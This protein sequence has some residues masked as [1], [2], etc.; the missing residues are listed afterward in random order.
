MPQAGA[1]RRRAAGAAASLALLAL[2]AAWILF[3]LVGHDPWKPDEAYSFGLV[4]DFL[5]RGD[6]VVP[7]LAGE[8]FLEKPPLFFITASAFA[9]GFGGM[10]PLHDAARLAGGFYMAVALAFLAATARELNRRHG[11][12]SVLIMLGCLGLVVRAH[13]L[14]TDLA[15]LAGVSMGMF[16]LALGR[17]TAL[18]GLALGAGAAVAFLSKGML[19]PGMLA[20]TALGLPMFRQWRQRTYVRTLIV[21]ALVAFP[22]VAAWMIALYLRSPDLFGTWLVT[23]NLGR[24]FGF[25]NIGPHQP[26]FFYAYTLLWYAFP[27]LPL[28]AWASVDACRNRNAAQA[29]PELQ[30]PLVLLAVVLGVL[31][32]AA[33]AR[34]LYLMPILLPLALLAS[35]GIERLPPAVGPALAKLGKGSFGAIALALWLGWIALLTGWPAPLA[36]VLADFQPGYVGQFSGP[37]F[38]I[39]IIGTAAWAL[40]VCPHATTA[41]LGV[42][43]W[44]FGV[45]LSLVLVGT[46]WLPYLDAGKSYRGMIESLLVHV[47]SDTCVSSRALGEPQR[48]MLHYYGGLKTVREE[49]V[50]GAQCSALLVQ[51][52]RRSGAP[53]P[54]PEWVAVWEGARPGDRN[55]LYVLYVRD[56]DGRSPQTRDDAAP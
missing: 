52:W 26:R 8:P 45:T 18:G 4:L 19:G 42:L 24:F 30:L 15:L 33:D 9:R 28:A 50:P 22:P 10:L 21:A 37:A 54:G 14:I 20:L 5:E 51:G 44:T 17:R 34:E 1:G 39:A 29:G 49:V 12:T 16:G 56:D 23:N 53:A 11:W 31:G 43:Q 41:Q 55:E 35:A 32:T 47:P 7:M 40:A 46:L 48:A 25:T 38:L 3:T 27:A 2:C 36:S 13:Q 6:W